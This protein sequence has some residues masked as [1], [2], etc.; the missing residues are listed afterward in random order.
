MF[1]NILM[2]LRIDN[3]MTQT[4]LANKIGVVKGTIAN[5]E[6]GLRKPDND[7]LIAL[8]EVFEVSVDYLLG[9]DVAK[10]NI[11]TPN[12][13]EVIDKTMKDTNLNIAGSYGTGKS[14]LLKKVA[15]TPS[16]KEQKLKDLIDEAKLPDEKLDILIDM[17]KSWK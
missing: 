12:F 10:H 11:I 14:S 17:I 9:L 7:K 13:D 8:A 5:Y 4:E 16:P 3:K 6:S 15:Y 1:K 2:Q